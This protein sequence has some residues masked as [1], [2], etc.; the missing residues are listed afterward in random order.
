MRH[1][2]CSQSSSIVLLLPFH[3][4]HRVVYAFEYPGTTGI[5]AY[6]PPSRVLKVASLCME[7]LLALKL[8]TATGHVCVDVG[9]H[10]GVGSASGALGGDA[11]D[12]GA[13]AVLGTLSALLSGPA[14]FLVIGFEA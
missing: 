6:N 11:C 7:A 8:V 13:N 14:P 12:R 3:P 4:A 5:V 2:I 9:L 1:T 10:L